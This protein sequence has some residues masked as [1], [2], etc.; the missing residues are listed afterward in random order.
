LGFFLKFSFWPAASS[1]RLRRSAV[2]DRRSAIGG[3]RSAR[4]S[5]ACFLLGHPEQSQ[6]VDDVFSE[7]KSQSNKNKFSYHQKKN[8]S[9][10]F[11]LKK[12]KPPQSLIYVG[13]KNFY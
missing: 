6:T 7:K 13:K 2:G 1:K 11:Y 4:S 9:F 5:R 12:I 3:R 10:L 8:K